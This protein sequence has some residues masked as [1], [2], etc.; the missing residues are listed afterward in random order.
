MHA[1]LL[2]FGSLEVDG[3]R[4]EHDLVIDGGAVR[5]RNK[6][7]SKPL[8]AQFGHT[9]LTADEELPWGG[10]RL[11]IGTGAYGSLPI[12]EGVVDE[13]DRRGIAVLAVPTREACRLISEL[14]PADVHA[15]L[16]VTC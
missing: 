3:R 7:A 8:R 1:R 14:D 16:H 15:V 6:K 4:Y 5:K 9:P 12:A 10:S 2:G 11:I 13:A